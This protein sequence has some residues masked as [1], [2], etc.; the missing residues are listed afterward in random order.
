MSDK[1]II[2]L[3]PS[4]LWCE[5]FDYDKEADEIY[6]CK[7]QYFKSNDVFELWEDC[8]YLHLKYAVQELK[9]EVE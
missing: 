6:E 3:P 2:E 4:C 1:R 5:E 9:E 8:P 7:V